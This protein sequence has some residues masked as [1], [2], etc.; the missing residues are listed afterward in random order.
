VLS[1]AAAGLVILVYW[2][3]WIGSVLLLLALDLEGVGTTQ[4]ILFLSLP[5]LF[6]FLG[7]YIAQRIA[8]AKLS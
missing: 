3:A 1:L 7:G 5:L 6:P 4:I 8:E 2:L